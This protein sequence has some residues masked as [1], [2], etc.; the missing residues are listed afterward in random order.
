RR[1]TPTT[2]ARRPPRPP[3]RRPRPGS[4]PAAAP[5]TAARAARATRSARATAPPRPRAA[6]RARARRR[7]S[8]PSSPSPRRCRAAARSAAPPR[9][10]AG[11]GPPVEAQQN[12]AAVRPRQR[13]HRRDDATA[14]LLARHDVGDGWRALRRGGRSLALAPPPLAAQELAREVAG[15]RRE[16]A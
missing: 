1:A 9:D 5:R 6:A 7:P 15:D 11:R 14:L 16:V 12:G 13:E 4:P 3:P 2:R 10:P 8:R